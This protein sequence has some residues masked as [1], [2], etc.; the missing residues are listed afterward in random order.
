MD[1]CMRG[2]VCAA[3]ERGC[4]CVRVC[5]E[6]LWVEGCHRG[7]GERLSMCI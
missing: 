2:A 3:G 5:R 1:V 7:C 6:R 4:M